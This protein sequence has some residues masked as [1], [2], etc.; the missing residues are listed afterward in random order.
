MAEDRELHFGENSPEY[1]AFRL[2]REIAHAED[3][4]ILGAGMGPSS[5]SDRKWILDT[6]AECLE[7]VRTPNARRP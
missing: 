2:F 5:K 6:Y 4:A 7:A 3:K 1:V